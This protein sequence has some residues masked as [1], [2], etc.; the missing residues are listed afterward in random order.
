[1]I[2]MFYDIMPTLLE[3]QKASLLWYRNVG[4]RGGSNVVDGVF[5]D[6]LFGDCV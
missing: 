3:V 1:L 2:V 4:V 5:V 6:M